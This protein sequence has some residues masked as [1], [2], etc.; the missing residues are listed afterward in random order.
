MCGGLSFGATDRPHLSAY[1]AERRQPPIPSI[2]SIVT[3]ASALSLEC[4]LI[5]RYCCFLLP[6]L[7]GEAAKRLSKA[8][9]PRVA[10]LFSTLEIITN[11]GMYQRSQN[12]SPPTP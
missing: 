2:R 9:A 1:R 10:A 11:R 12:I 3:L 5:I 4:Q 6:A 8:F 7:C